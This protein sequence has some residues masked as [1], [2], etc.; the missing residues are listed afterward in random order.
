MAYNK[1]EGNYDHEEKR[2]GLLSWFRK[3]RQEEEDVKPAPRTTPA[4]RHKKAPKKKEAPKDEETPKVQ[5]QY[6]PFKSD[7]V[8]EAGQEVPDDPEQKNYPENSDLTYEKPEPDSVYVTPEPQFD[9]HGTG[10]SFFLIFCNF[11]WGVL[12]LVHNIKGQRSF[13]T[14]DYATAKEESDKS[15]SCGVTA[16]AVGILGWII[17]SIFDIPIY[18]SYIPYQLATGLISFLFF[19]YK[20][21]SE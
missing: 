6:T 13:D 1:S 16:I 3:D 7:S 4:P 11:Y 8:A 20:K 19:L 17:C 9:K 15:N 18:I 2:G 10:F 5:I 12:A 14:E 21:S